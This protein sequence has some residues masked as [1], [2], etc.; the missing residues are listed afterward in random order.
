[1]TDSPL[2]AKECRRC[3]AT[4]AA[5]E[6]YAKREARDGLQPYCKSCTRAAKIIWR[7][8]ASEKHLAIEAR[9][10]AKR[11]PRRSTSAEKLSAYYAVDRAVKSGE[12]VKA[13]AC[14]RC[15]ESGTTLV[16][17][18]E[19]YGRPLDVIWLCRGCHRRYHVGL[20]ELPVRS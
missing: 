14:E 10:R 12:L 15:G 16:G 3:G 13:E 17:H 1:M 6:F 5:S 2:V 18:H 20:V 8:Q 9:Y 7:Q 19:D 11:G 4:K